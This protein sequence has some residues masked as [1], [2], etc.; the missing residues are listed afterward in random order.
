MWSEVAASAGAWSEVVAAAPPQLPAD[1]EPV[2]SRQQ[3]IEEHQIRRLAPHCRQP[4]GAGPGR[5]HL[6]PLAAQIEL[7]QLENIGL[8]LDDDDFFS[9][10]L[11]VRAPPRAGIPEAPGTER[12]ATIVKSI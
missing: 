11:K 2:D 5:G 4:F 1:V 6:V 12:L 10:H 8:V 7:E 9:G 3:Q